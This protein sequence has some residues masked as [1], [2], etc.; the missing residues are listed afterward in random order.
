MPAPVLAAAVASVGAAVGGTGVGVGVA[1]GGKNAKDAALA[2][3]EATQAVNAT[4]DKAVGTVQ[5]VGLASAGASA[6]NA[7]AK[8]VS[9]KQS[10]TERSLGGWS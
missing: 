1:V 9:G 3:A 2:M 7:V 10:S 4:A 8:I 6:S 5:V